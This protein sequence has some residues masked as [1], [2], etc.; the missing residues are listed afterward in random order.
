MKKTIQKLRLKK[1]TLRQLDERLRSVEGGVLG[2]TINYTVWTTRP[3]TCVQSD[4]CSDTC[5]SGCD[6]C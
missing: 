5:V 1:E 4:G 2:P 3:Y 6:W